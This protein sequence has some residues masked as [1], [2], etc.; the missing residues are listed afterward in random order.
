MQDE[1]YSRGQHSLRERIGIWWQ[2]HISG[3]GRTK[4]LLSGLAAIIIVILVWSFLVS[5][6]S[7][8]LNPGESQPKAD[9]WTNI[10]LPQW[11]KPKHYDLDLSTID[12]EQ[13]QFAG[14]VSISLIIEDPTKFVV[15]HSVDLNVD[16]EVRLVGKDLD[17]R[18]VK[19]DVRP[20]RQYTLFWFERVLPQGEYTL[21]LRFKGKLT[22]SLKGFYY[23]QYP[24]MDGKKRYIATTQFEPTDARAAFPVSPLNRIGPRLDPSQCLILLVLRRTFLKSDVSDQHHSTRRLSRPQQHAA[25]INF[26]ALRKVH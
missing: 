1:Q 3:P 2:T 4:H 13:L 26:I 18:P 17:L 9:N 8:D 5:G 14:Y 21:S 15:L 6:K 10:R 23:S 16:P 19:T 7:P 12:F 24:T 22:D 11:I 25:H 20:Q